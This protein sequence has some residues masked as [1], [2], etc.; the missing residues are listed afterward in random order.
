MTALIKELSRR[1]TL[2]L[3]YNFWEIIIRSA[4]FGI[5]SY[6]VTLICDLG[7]ENWIR[8]VLRAYLQMAV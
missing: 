8:P 7:V 4:E 3:E 5:L 6:T 2:L 1:E